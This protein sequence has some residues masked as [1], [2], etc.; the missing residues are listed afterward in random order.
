MNVTNR[1][2]LV[3]DI[4][5][6]KKDVEIAEKALDKLKADKKL[7][8]NKLKS[9]LSKANMRI[10]SLEEDNKALSARSERISELKVKELEI[11]EREKLL[12]AKEKHQNQ[13]QSEIEKLEKKSTIAKDMGY[14]EGYADGVADGVRKGLE[15]S[16]DDRRMMAQIAALAAASHNGEATAEIAKQVA[17]GIGKSISELPATTRTEDDEA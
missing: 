8:I 16:A 3:M 12:D 13:Y 17:N 10:G 15:H 11:E 1:G 7:E 9:E 2:I 4:F 14:K 5:K 6:N